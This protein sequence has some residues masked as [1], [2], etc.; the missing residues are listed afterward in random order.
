M[1]DKELKE[2]RVS[3]VSLGCDKNRVDLERILYAL[4][5]Y[6]FSIVNDGEESD[7]VI[8]N[9][10]A[11]ILPAR[12]EA[13][14]EILQT[15]A[16][17]LNGNVE[18]IIVTGCLNEKGL[19]E[20]KASLPEVD[21]FVPIREN[22]KIV[23]VIENMYGL[24]ESKN[25]CPHDRLLTGVGHYAFLKIADGCNNMC[26]YCTIP[27]I[28]G[29]YI[30]VPIE[31]LIKEAKA[32][33]KRGVKELIIVAQDSTR[34]G[35]DLYKKNRFTELI[36]KLSEIKELVWIRLLYCYPEKVD[37]ALLKTIKNNPK[38]CK[39]IDVPLQHI[40]NTVL[41]NMN[42]RL[43]EVET[44]ELIKKIRS[45][46]PEITIR[47]TFILGFPGESKGQFG[48]LCK[49]LKD[50]RFDYAGFFPYSREEGTRAYFMKKR[51]IGITKKNRVK[52]ATKIQK[53][54]MKERCMAKIGTEAKVLI[55]YFDTTDGYYVGHTEFITPG[56]DPILKVEDNGK[57]QIGNFYNIKINSFENFEF[58]GEVL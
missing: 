26:S 3:A 9:T 19:D 39:Y 42:R 43:P 41:K 18:K 23:S 13:V 52:K 44:R 37:E 40:D 29:R 50:F 5:D 15:V 17:K 32:L 54:V 31:E 24:K 1:T 8:I 14:K 57:I 56:V 20:L 45:E 49:F 21:A 46:Y 4:K 58:R 48:G 7:I 10:C 11:F 2:K 12:E 55:D 38:V 25:S 36:E 35:E 22:T 53:A 51:C 34:Y 33:V 30:S 6:G 27:R 28:R 16:K 47:S